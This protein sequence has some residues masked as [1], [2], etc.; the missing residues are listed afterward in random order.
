MVQ[1]FGRI[2]R[3]AIVHQTKEG[4][5]VVNFSIALN[6]WYKPKNGEAKKI[7]AYVNCAYWIKPESA[8]YLTKGK[9][10]EVNGRISVSAYNNMQ[11]EAVGSINFHVSNFKLYGS[12]TAKKSDP[13][14]EKPA[15]APDDLPF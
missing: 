1:L 4:K 8:E 13:E 15:S 9:V 3:D 7:V 2:T 14:F 5:K 6:D 12:D 11:G 10:V